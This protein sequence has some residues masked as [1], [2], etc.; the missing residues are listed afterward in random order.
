MFKSPKKL[1]ATLA[2]E[3]EHRYRSTACPIEEALIDRLSDLTDHVR[4]TAIEQAWSV[5]WTE[6]ADHRRKLAKSRAA[7]HDWLTLR[8]LGEIIAMLGQA[9]RYYRKS[10]GAAN[11][12]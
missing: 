8:E 2:P 10:S 5:D 11:V 1:P 12:H 9:A 4:E 6:L 7:H 3:E